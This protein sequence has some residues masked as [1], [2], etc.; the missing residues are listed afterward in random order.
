MPIIGLNI[1]SSQAKFKFSINESNDYDIIKR[2]LLAN[3][4]RN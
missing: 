4:N 1:H 2:E 3:Y